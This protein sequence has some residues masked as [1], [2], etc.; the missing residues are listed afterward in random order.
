MRDLSHRKI[1]ASNKL[2]LCLFR[3]L[4]SPRNAEMSFRVTRRPYYLT[5]SRFRGSSRVVRYLP[6]S[7]A[8]CKLRFMPTYTC[9]TVQECSGV[10]K[11]FVRHLYSSMKNSEHFVADSRTEDA[12]A[13]LFSQH[14]TNVPV[15]A[16]CVSLFL[17]IYPARIL[18]MANVFRLDSAVFERACPDQAFP[19]PS[20]RVITRSHLRLWR[21][22]N[23]R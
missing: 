6:R 17:K 22:L 2:S 18:A 15:R 13:F 21:M 11:R 5:P 9:S 3:H 16:L 20:F 12:A 14:A 19:S 23:S 4:P 8:R 7:Q 1:S 10:V